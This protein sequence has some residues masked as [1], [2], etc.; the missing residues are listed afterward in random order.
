MNIHTSALTAASLLA[1]ALCIG[2]AAAAPLLATYPGNPD[3][4][5]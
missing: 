4:R 5:S 1:A 3:A 2:S